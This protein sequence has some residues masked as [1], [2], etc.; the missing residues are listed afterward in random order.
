MSLSELV[1]VMLVTLLTWLGLFAYILKVD[2]KI[3]RLEK[4]YK[5]S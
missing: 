2:L 1:T 4:E 3:S 5:D